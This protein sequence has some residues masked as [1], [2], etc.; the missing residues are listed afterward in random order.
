MLFFFLSSDDFFFKSTFSKISF[1]NTI[2]VS[3]CF[4]PDQAQLDPSCLQIASMKKIA[5]SREELI[6]VY[7]LFSC[8][9]FFIL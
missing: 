2:R 4:D 8:I 3:N 1:R 7:T 5:I 6:R 9:F